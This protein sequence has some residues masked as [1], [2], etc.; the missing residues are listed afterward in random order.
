MFGVVLSGPHGGSVGACRRREE[1][2]SPRKSIIKT[3]KQWNVV[4]HVVVFWGGGGYNQIHVA[5]VDGRASTLT[6]RRLV[7]VVAVALRFLPDIVEIGKVG[8][9]IFLM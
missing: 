9:Y 1:E 5:I 4:V 8:G 7:P 3:N 6:L 2:L